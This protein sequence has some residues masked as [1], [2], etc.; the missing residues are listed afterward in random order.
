MTISSGGENCPGCSACTGPFAHVPIRQNFGPTPVEPEITAWLS[1]GKPCYGIDGDMVV[2][3]PGN[4]KNMHVE[5]IPRKRSF[6]ARLADS[7]RGRK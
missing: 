3:Y 7:V 1:D 2:L 4:S 5:V 6:L